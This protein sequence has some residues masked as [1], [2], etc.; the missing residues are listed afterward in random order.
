[1][2]LLCLLLLAVPLADAESAERLAALRRERADVLRREVALR[3]RDFR[4]DLSTWG[5]LVDAAIRLRQAELDLAGTDP[6]KQLAAHRRLRQTL[7]AIEPVN[8]VRRADG[9]LTALEDTWFQ[10]VILDADIG[11]T[12]AEL[13]RPGADK[14]QLRRQLDELW[15]RRVAAARTVATADAREYAAGRLSLDVLLQARTD[16]AAAERRDADAA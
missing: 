1:M 12:E 6:D 11:K 13:R 2:S 10:S 3:T 14:D 5:F 4:D 7:R 8:R 15:R 9:R 16:L